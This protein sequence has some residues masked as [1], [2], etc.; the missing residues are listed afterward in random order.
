MSTKGTTRQWQCVSGL[1][2]WI[3]TAFPGNPASPV[4]PVQGLGAI[5]RGIDLDLLHMLSQLGQSPVSPVVDSG[6]GDTE[7]AGDMLVAVALADDHSDHNS[8]AVG[9]ALQTLLEL[10]G[11]NRKGP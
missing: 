6:D 1:E 7:A 9:Q 11:I 4:D 5:A 10:L 2:I 3:C 8:F